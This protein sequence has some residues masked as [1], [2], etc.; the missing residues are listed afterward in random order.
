MKQYKTPQLNN[1]RDIYINQSPT[2]FNQY[3][4]EK[5]NNS[6]YINHMHY[7]QKQNRPNEYYEEENLE[8]TLKNLKFKPDFFINELNSMKESMEQDKK[9]MKRSI[10]AFTNQSPDK[11]NEYIFQNINQGVDD[12]QN[13]RKNLKYKEYEHRSYKGE[14]YPLKFFRSNPLI[15][16]TNYN[17]NINLEDVE[18]LSKSVA[19]KICNITI[20]GGIKLYKGKKLKSG[21]K[22]QKKS[23]NENIE[24]EP[25]IPQGSSVPDKNINFNISA[26]KSKMSS[27]NYY[28][29]YEDEENEEYENEEIEEKEEEMPMRQER[30]IG[31]LR[32]EQRKINKK[33]IYQKEREENNEKYEEERNSEIINKERETLDEEQEN[34]RDIED[35]EDE[36]DLEQEETEREQKIT[37]REEQ[38]VG[39]EEVEYGQIEQLEDNDEKENNEQI[40][41]KENEEETHRINKN[42]IEA[43]EKEQQQ[44][45][46]TNNIYKNK[47]KKSI[48]KFQK[49]NEIKISGKKEA[50][51][52]QKNNIIIKDYNI[53]II[54]DKKPMIFEINEQSKL[55]LLKRENHENHP[56]TSIQKVQS[57][58]QPKVE[59][60]KIYKKQILNI[61]KNTEN[62][63]EITHEEAQ[64]DDSTFEIQKV[65]NFIQPRYRHKKTKNIKYLKYKITKNPEANFIL[66]K[67]REEPELIIENVLYFEQNPIKKNKKIKLEIVNNKDG[68]IEIIGK[69]SM[70]ICNENNISFPKIFRKSVYKKYTYNKLKKSKRI[71][72]QYVPIKI[73]NDLIVTP[74]ESRFMIRGK[75]KKKSKE[76]RN[77]VKR[78]ITCNYKSQIFQELLIGGKINNTIESALLRNNI[79]SNNNINNEMR[80]KS[81]YFTNSMANNRKIQ[82]ISNTNV[83]NKQNLINVYINSKSN[84]SDKK[85]DKR[86][87]KKEKNRTFKTATILSSNLVK[88]ESE[89]IKQEHISIRRKYT[90]SRSNKN[91]LINQNESIKLNNFYMGSPRYN[92]PS[93]NNSSKEKVVKTESSSTNISKKQVFNFISP[94]RYEKIDTE[95][96]EENNKNNHIGRNNKLLSKYETYNNDKLIKSENNNIGK[97]QSYFSN[98]ESN[99]NNNEM[100]KT[101]LTKEN[102]NLFINNNYYNKSHTTTNFSNRQEHKNSCRI[103]ISSN[104]TNQ[105]NESD[106]SSKK[107]SEKYSNTGRI[108]VTTTHS[109]NKGTI[110][111]APKSKM[112]SKKTDSNIINSIYIATNFKKDKI[113]NKSENKN[114]SKE[115]TNNSVF[116][117]SSF[118]T[119]KSEQNQILNNNI[120]FSSRANTSNLSNIKD[121]DNKSETK[122][123]INTINIVNGLT[124]SPVML[125]NK[126]RL[127]PMPESNNINKNMFNYDNNIITNERINNIQNVNILEPLNINENDKNEKEEKN[128]LKVEKKN[129][130]NHAKY[131]NKTPE[132]NEFNKL[133]HNFGGSLNTS[134]FINSGNESRNEEKNN[135][136]NKYSFG[137]NG[138]LSCFPNSYL[139]SNISIG[140]RPE[141]SDFSKKYLS[142]NYSTNLSNRPELSNITRAY[143]ISQSPIVEND[144]DK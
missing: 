44:S 69:P 93:S 125:K 77:I 71:I 1:F 5:E 124:N 105:R 61:I 39:Q 106:E 24:I 17:S 16:T 9:F 129:D 121:K 40:L 112:E 114:A 108:Y 7:I 64:R 30:K 76:G 116:Y 113:D 96:K 74:K 19:Q 43:L 143:L 46:I 117:S 85:E 60:K 89:P 11:L 118:T 135:V 70:I 21:K 122:T 10:N 53:E 75:A 136:F 36:E 42:E 2:Y 94:K 55:E 33:I 56:L 133:L 66:E 27:S 15:Q 14:R 86:E 67:S 8:K 90:N 41:E 32:I 52:K 51:K 63:V 78:E 87:D 132:N 126:D 6:P 29:E 102:N 4:Y 91:I 38:N 31:E 103:Y 139:N 141:L 3:R 83:N 57:L 84:I 142:T 12:P 80:N 119:K 45:G 49:E 68:I 47:G 25:N 18:N 35:E 79:N 82:S 140:P 99:Y 130:E 101:S 95:K 88:H 98:K 23:S 110:N 34:E 59:K 131:E 134:N 48:L 111:N 115:L 54:R 120:F 26:T 37:E 13:N 58:E 73:I 72:H 81:K 20:K 138:Q 65:Q 144:D 104:K 123:N 97:I 92:G 107:E 50:N 128:N 137:G 109:I 28:E 127:G 22:C 100:P 62:N